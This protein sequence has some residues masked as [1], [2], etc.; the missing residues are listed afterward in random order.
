MITFEKKSKYGDFNDTL[1]MSIDTGDK[2]LNKK[3]NV[4][5]CYGKGG[6]GGGSQTS[7]L[8]ATFSFTSQFTANTESVT[9]TGQNARHTGI[10]EI[11]Q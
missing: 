7:S 10:E 3:L 5:L 6:G 1:G 9:Y 2:W 11:N 8:P 4:N